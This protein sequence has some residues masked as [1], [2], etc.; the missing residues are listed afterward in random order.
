MVSNVW[1]LDDPELVT[2]LDRVPV[3][4]DLPTQLRAL[5]KQAVALL[6]D[7][8]R[9]ELGVPAY[10]RIEF[11]RREM[12]K[13]R[14]R[15]ARVA[16]DKLHRAYDGL[17]ALNPKQRLEIA[18][19]FGLMLEVMNACE[20]AYRTYRLAQKPPEKF[21]SRPDAII[22]VLTAH[23]SEARSPDNILVFHAIQESL[24]AALAAGFDGERERLRHLLEIV[25]RLS[26]ARRMKPS[27]SDEAEHLYSIL[28][29]P[30]TLST[31]LN[32]SREIAP[33]Y[34][35]TWVGGDKDGHPGVDENAMLASMQKAREQIVHFAQDRVYEVAAAAS[36][37]KEHALVRRCSRIQR[38]LAALTGIRPGDGARVVKVR[39]EVR[40]LVKEYEQAIGALHPALSQLM[41]LLHM[42]PGMVVPLELRESSDVIMQTA[43][44]KPAAIKRMLQRL[45]AIARGGSPG[46]Y[47]RGFIVSMAGSVEHIRAACRLVDKALHG[48]KIPVI[49]LFEQQAALEHAPQIVAGILK[50]ARVRRAVR[51]HW[52]GYFE[53]ML[54]YSDSAKEI[55]VL[56]SRLAIAEAVHKLDHLCRAKRVQ[57]LFFHGSGGSVDRGGGSVQE[58]TAWWPKSALRVYKATV[59]GEMVERSFA[60]PEIAR[61]QLERITELYAQGGS[62]TVRSPAAVEYFAAQVRGHYEAKISAPH[63]LEVVQKATAY[64]YL[65]ALKIG[66]RPSKRGAV[67]DVRALRAIPW[68]LCWTQTRVLFPTWWG[69]GTAW[70]QLKPAQRAALGRAFKTD[71]LFR[72][73]VKVLGFTLAKV[74]LPVWGMYLERSGL[75]AGLIAQTRHDFEKEYREAVRFVRALSGSRDLLWFRP[76]LGTSIR[77]RAPMIHPLNLMQIITLEERNAALTRETVTGIASGMMTTG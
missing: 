28:L 12:A 46:W 50:S 26:V 55:G 36:L 59:Q 8:I 1:S 71:P 66:S 15:S 24:Q 73:F 18:H 7:V 6:G 68:V 21:K 57:P 47:A 29:R 77:L 39:H 38:G 63:F 49:P 23:P 40:R 19:S 62:P 58:Q 22:Y 27:V 11:L 60:S 13:T 20:N 17:R 9:D 10:R 67:T 25:W 30:E 37:V 3:Q 74:E 48:L 53:I 64:R 2:Q 5:V 16:H 54:G 4:N 70:R 69:V 35:R 33:F 72:S 44:G 14:G 75:D 41:R 42:F 32:A 34:V 31:L 43:A 56:A 76:W 65:S 52:S 45:G 51:A 61:R